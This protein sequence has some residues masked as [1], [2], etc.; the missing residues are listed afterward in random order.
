MSLRSAGHAVARGLEQS[1]IVEGMTATTP[2]RPALRVAVWV[3]V[4]GSSGFMA[5]L[6]V[7]GLLVKAGVIR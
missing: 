1:R 2:P 4:L 6:G 3:L 7:M 5:V